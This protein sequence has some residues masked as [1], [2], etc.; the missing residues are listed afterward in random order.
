MSEENKTA[1]AAP[2][3][4]KPRAQKNLEETV[5]ARAPAQAAPAPINNNRGRNRHAIAFRHDVFVTDA[6]DC[7][8]N[9]SYKALDPKLEPVP[10]KHIFHSH[11]NNGKAMNRTG[12]AAGHFHYVEQ[13][14]DSVGNICA[15]C[16][17]AMHEV[18]HV[19]EDGSVYS[20]IEPVTFKKIQRGGTD[21]ERGKTVLIADDHVHTLEFIGWENLNPQQIKEELEKQQSLAA[22]MGISLGQGSIQNNTPE[23]MSPA[24]GASIRGV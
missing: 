9:V 15:K 3:A 11:T 1:P 14:T 10:H 7:L 12:S 17:P 4:A 6:K 22:T 16:G 13:Y 5:A 21:Q 8:K 24:D 23:P 19:A 2:A 20:R 18:Q